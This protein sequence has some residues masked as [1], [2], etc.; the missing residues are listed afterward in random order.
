MLYET[1]FEGESARERGAAVLVLVMGSAVALVL[2]GWGPWWL[3][4]ALVSMLVIALMLVALL[5]VAVVGIGGGVNG[6]VGVSD[7]GVVL[8]VDPSWCLL[9]LDL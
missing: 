4:S 1:Q 7:V 8:R 2:M 3:M 9:C 6:G 5:L